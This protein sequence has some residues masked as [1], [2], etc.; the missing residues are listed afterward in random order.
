MSKYIDFIKKKL[1]IYEIKEETN[2]IDSTLP[3]E[4][5]FKTFKLPIEYLEQTNTYNMSSVVSN[6]LELIQMYNHLLSPSHMFA[7]Q[8]ILK[9]S[10]K[11]TTN[12]FF[13]KETQQVIESIDNLNQSLKEI[14]T[15]TDTEC[16]Q[17]TQIWKSLKN[18]EYFLD[19][20]GYMDIDMFLYL[21]NS[22]YFLE[23][24][25]IV[26]LMTPIYN[27]FIPFI[28]LI[29]PFILLRIQCVPLTF[30]SYID[31]LKEIAK[32]SSFGKLILNF[33]KGSINSTNVFG[34]IVSVVFYLFQMYQS[35]SSSIKFYKNFSKINE[36]LNV[37]KKFVYRS[38]LQMESFVLL[39]KN[40][41]TYTP[42][43][44]DI[45]KH[46]S[47]LNKIMNDLVNVNSSKIINN[48]T[49]LG[50]LL[51]CYYV[52]HSNEEYEESIRFMIGFEGY[53][54][55]LQG[56][57]KNMQDKHINYARFS[58]NNCIVKNQYYPPFI[59]KLHVKNTCN[60][61][62]NMIITGVNAS[63]KTTVLKT[64]LINII[65]SQQFGCG[66]Y[67]S[68]ALNPYTHIHSYLNIPDTSGRDSLFQ[69]ETRRCK[70]IID[71][72][73]DKGKTINCRHFC[74]FDEL[75][76]GTNPIEASKCACALLLYLSKYENVNFMLTTHYISICKKIKMKSFTCKTPIKNYK[77]LIS[78]NLDGTIKYDYKMESGICKIEGAVNVLKQM[79]Y[80]NEIIQYVQHT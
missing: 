61:N 26:N 45:M 40:K 33:C 9:W 2:I 24:I 44:Q 79:N 8:M 53:L 21:N 36:D 38:T 69:A 56:I 75:Y 29:I 55:N 17:I 67:Q 16:K 34:I 70:E 68:F 71:V 76:S 73:N 1:S 41:S 48:I 23:L 43:C 19:K 5:L 49:N 4:P 35:I 18:D 57:H 78:K 47:I 54:N 20:Y 62:N 64:T 14:N 15:C 27:I 37:F 72:I 31:I 22:S 10:E 25:T 3:E 51:K 11:Y 32:N 50:Y 80:P 46:T 28:I 58:K 7:K 39:N 6:D 66:F 63:G 42:F 59:N 12:V 60:L 65:L 52:L 13:L 30:N 77:M 74:I